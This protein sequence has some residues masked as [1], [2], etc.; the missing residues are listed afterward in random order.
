MCSQGN[1]CEQGNLNVKYP[2]VSP[3]FEA[4]VLRLNSATEHAESI[5]ANEQAVRRFVVEL[6][7]KI[8]F[9]R[10][11][12]LWSSM[13]FCNAIYHELTKIL[14]S[15]STYKKNSISY[16]TKSKKPSSLCF[17]PKSIIYNHYNYRV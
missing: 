6:F 3:S 14:V 11:M 17:F 7:P 12:C 2:D 13:F 4:L 16:L 10:A 8:G 5:G 15:K 1:R 9:G